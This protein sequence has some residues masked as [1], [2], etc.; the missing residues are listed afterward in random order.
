MTSIKTRNISSIE[1]EEWF[2]ESV[3]WQ[4]TR[5]KTFQEFLKKSRTGAKTVKELDS[6]SD[7]KSFNSFVAEHS[8]FPNW[9]AFRNYAELNFFDRI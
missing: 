4:T 9:Q 8:Q 5:F 1:P 3:M 7:S 6:L 2:T